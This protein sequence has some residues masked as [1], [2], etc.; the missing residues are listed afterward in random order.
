MSRLVG[1]YRSTIGKKIIMAVTGLIG[2][3]FLISH[4]ASNLL[5]F[6]DPRHLDEYG[7]FLRSLGALLWVARLGLIVAVV[8]H[9]VMAVQLTARKRAARPVDYQQRSPQV[10]TWGSRTMFVGGL[11]LLAFIVFHILHFT[12]G[13][14]T[15]GFTF[16]HGEVGRNVIEGFRSWP[17]VL[18]YV[19]AMV[20]LG[21]HLYHGAWS[22]LRTLGAATP[23]GK[24]LRRPIVAIVAIAL[25]IGFAIIPLAIGAGLVRQPP[26]VTADAARPAP[27]AAA[28]K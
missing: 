11:L 12:L 27:A 21:L 4:V 26:P 16:R 20:F 9:V 22:S 1:F 19:V 17:V 15:P 18:F 8:L 10:S 25:A 5:I 24:P 23:G 2:L 13:A 28:Q 6:R 14:V 7:A 3:A